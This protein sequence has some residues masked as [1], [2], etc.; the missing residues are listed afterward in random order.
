VTDKDR[1]IRE[2]QNFWEDMYLMS[3]NFNWFS[4]VQTPSKVTAERGTEKF[5]FSTVQ[6]PSK[7]TAERGTEKFWFSS[8][9]TPSKVTA[10]RGKGK[11]VDELLGW[12]A[13]GG[14]M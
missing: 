2:E 11:S 3:M 4:A 14:D 1:E 6:T 13:G 5:W 10:E 12:G 7:V 8:V 9:Q